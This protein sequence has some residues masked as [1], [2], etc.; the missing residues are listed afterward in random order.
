MNLDID[1]DTEGLKRDKIIDVMKDYFGHRKVIN[2]CT[3]AQLSSKTAL[4][5]AGKGL[6]YNNDDIDFLKAMIPIERGQIWSLSDC[7]N[8][9]EKKKREP[10]TE[11]INQLNNNYPDL[12]EIAFELEGLISQKGIHASGVLILNDDY[13]KYNACMRSSSGKIITQFDLHD[14]EFFSG[15]KFDFLTINALDK[16]RK[17]IDFLIENG[18]MEWKGSLKKTYD[19]YLHPTVLEYEDEKMWNMIK[20]I[21]SIF[22]FDTKVGVD[23][24]NKVNPRSIIDLTVANSLMRLMGD[25]TETPL[26]IYVRYKEDINRW[27]SDM[28]EYRLNE[29]EIEV[30]KKHLLSSYG[31]ADSQEKVMQLSMD[32]KISNFSLG[33]ANKLRKS[34]AK[35]DEQVLEDTKENFFE[36]G[37]KNGTRQIFLDYVWYQVFAKSFGYSFSSIH[38]HEYST[39]AV[40]EMNLNFKFP[41]IYWLAS[42][43]CVDSGS[44]ED[45]SIDNTDKKKK[46]TDY[47]RMATALSNIMDKGVKVA[48]P[49]VNKANF[50]FIPDE[51]NNEIIFGLKGISGVGDSIAHEIINNRPYMSIEDFHK[52]L[53]LTKQEVTLSTGKKQNKSLVPL[54]S[55]ISLIKAGAFDIIENNKTRKQIMHDYL[56]LN[57]PNKKTLDMRAV[58]NVVALG[59]APEQ[60][61]L[62]IRVNGFKNYV[63]TKENFIKDDEEKKSKKWY[64]LRGHNEETTQKTIQFFEEYFM[65]NMNEGTDYYYDEQGNIIFACKLK[66]TGF[67]KTFDK[68]TS[69]LKQW[70]KSSDCLD[71]YNSFQFNEVWNKYAQG[72]ISKWEMDSLSFYYHEHELANV[73]KEKYYIKDFNELSEEPEIDR[74]G[75]YRGREYPIFKLDRIAGTVLDKDKNKH[76]VTLLTINGEVVTLKFYSGQFG[77]YD[78]TI[79]EQNADGT[80][81]TIEESWFKRGNKLLVAGYRRGEQFKPKK[82]KD[83][84][85]QHAV[86]LIEEVRDDGVLILKTDRAKV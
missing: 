5:L 1:F 35:K 80:K 66:S 3:Y 9:N 83:S 51:K 25:G 84:A 86:S 53:V 61:K 76:M 47:G 27:F 21:Y 34:I 41:P 31:L 12:L 71:R 63:I 59:I 67:E 16:V 28:K 6:G 57:F 39:I 49:H 2:V 22:Q 48:L 69:E 79:S 18:K 64:I 52:R 74:Y 40:Q 32:E 26:D 82:Y 7:I 19:Y 75:Q 14:S 4:Q 55:A 23:A 33:E 24:V 8:G 46:T 72:T 20:N 42:C 62:A 58:E 38:C 11:F 56:K 85:F 77:F 29:E 10:I 45:E 54:G 30:M 44:L 37:L 43:L 36:K 70:L 17:T 68:L 60:H 15:I 65:S 78:K 73:N 50:G 13:T 81:T